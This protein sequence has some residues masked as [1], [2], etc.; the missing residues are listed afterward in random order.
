MASCRS[1]GPRECDSSMIEE[2]CPSSR[3]SHL[4]PNNMKYCDNASEY[5]RSVD[6][7][8]YSITDTENVSLSMK[9][10]SGVENSDSNHQSSLQTQSSVNKQSEY[11]DHIDSGIVEDSFLNSGNDGLNI[12]SRFANLSTDE[13]RNISTVPPPVDFHELIFSKD[14]DGDT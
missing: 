1:R 3:S 5:Q 6:E 7:G 12:I 9:A 11:S 10:Q 13:P 14:E 8:I 4:M 2:D